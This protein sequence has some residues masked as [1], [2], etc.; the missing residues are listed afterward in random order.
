MRADAKVRRIDGKLPRRESGELCI[1]TSNSEAFG[2]DFGK[3]Y[4]KKLAT[5]FEVCYSPVLDC[6]TIRLDGIGD[7]M[8]IR[9]MLGFP[10]RLDYWDMKTVQGV[11][12]IIE[13]DY[14]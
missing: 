8:R 6:H 5:A 9:K 3:L 1:I 7:L 10:V 13:D 12:I 2:L 4:G 11:A 14:K